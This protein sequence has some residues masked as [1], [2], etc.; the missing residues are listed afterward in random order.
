MIKRTV[1]VYIG[2]RTTLDK[3]ADNERETTMEMVLDEI[4]LSATKASCSKSQ[5]RREGLLHIPVW[6]DLMIQD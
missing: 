6:V 1:V 2:C 3:L 4:E 5:C